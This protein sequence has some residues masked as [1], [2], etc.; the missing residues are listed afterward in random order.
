MANLDQEKDI[1]RAMIRLYCRKK[2]SGQPRCADCR[3][4]TEYVNLRLE[5]CPFR[6]GKPTCKNC[7]VHC[8]QPEMRARI[9]EV[10]RFSGPR[11]ILHHPKMAIQHMMQEIFSH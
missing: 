9:R 6:E 3:E 2:H 5:K 1:V 8:Y 4:L 10:M 7:P 11:M